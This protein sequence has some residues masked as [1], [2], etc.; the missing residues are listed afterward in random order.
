MSDRI[1]QISGQGLDTTDAEMRALMTNMVNADTPGFKK[2][3]PIVRSFSSYLDDAVRGGSYSSAPGS[4]SEAPR[5]TGIA[6]DSTRGFLKPTNN[7]LDCALSDEGYFVVQSPSG[8]LFTRDGRFQLDRDGALRTVAGNYTVLGRSGPIHVTAGSPLTIS[9]TGDVLSGSEKVD[10]L[11]VEQVSKPDA[12]E[13]LGG[14]FFRLPENDRGID[15]KEVESPQVVQG[16]VEMSNVEIVDQIMRMVY[17]NRL[18]SS[19][20]KMI[21]TREQMLSRALDLARQD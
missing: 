11:R 12:L 10:T 8:E 20:T 17:D 19:N 4:S 2:S 9:P 13:N 1:F 5:V 15:I 6:I 7:P 18:Y 21:Q 16:F 3:Y 14:V